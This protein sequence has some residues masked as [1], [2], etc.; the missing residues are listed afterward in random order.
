MVLMAL[1]HFSFDLNQFGIIHENMNH[2]PFWLNFR[3]VIM[4]LFL[5]LVGI[6]FQ[7]ARTEY[8]NKNYQKRLL[9]IFVC[10]LL[11]SIATYFVDS[12][13]WIFFGILHLIFFASL[14]GPIL[15]RFPLISF[16]A[17]FAAILLPIF[18]QNIFFMRPIW[19]LSGLSPIKPLTEDFAPIFPWLGVVGIGV[20][21]GAWFIK[22]KLNFG[23]D[24]EIHLLT[25]LGQNSLV[26][27]MTHQLILFPLA[28]LISRV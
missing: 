6:S 26:F 16:L 7:F 22:Q 1:Y 18:Y 28:W 5:S 12:R 20:G 15:N 24:R 10:A 4:T 14:L 2:D 21:I 3:A 13:T 17:G 9:K 23:F 19:N 11:I 25:W 27:Y 8:K